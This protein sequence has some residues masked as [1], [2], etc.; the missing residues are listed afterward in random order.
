MATIKNR[1]LNSFKLQQQQQQLRWRW[2]WQWQSSPEASCRSAFA[3]LSR[4]SYC[5]T[6]Y[7]KSYCR[8]K[9]HGVNKN[10]TLCWLTLTLILLSCSSWHGRGGP[11]GRGGSGGGGGGGG[12]AFCYALDIGKCENTLCLLFLPI[13][14]LHRCVFDFSNF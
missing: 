4:C 1:Q 10:K 7:L 2:R 6:N 11:G 12:G 5:A 9:R 13:P 8:I 3:L 14:L